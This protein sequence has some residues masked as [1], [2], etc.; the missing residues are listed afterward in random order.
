M[1]GKPYPQKP[2]TPTATPASPANPALAQPQSA[3]AP[4]PNPA[5]V[6]PPPAS[7][8]PGRTSPGSPSAGG[9]EPV[10]TVPLNRNSPAQSTVTSM[11]D[12]S[13]GG[14]DRQK[15]LRSRSA[16][17]KPA[18]L[19]SLDAFRGF[20]MTMLAAG[21]FGLLAFS[22][23]DESSP[24]WQTHNRELWLRIGQHFNHPDW[25]SSFDIFKVSFWDLIQP[26]F[27]FMVGAAMPFS[28][29]RREAEGDGMFSRG[30]HAIT[31]SVMLV[32]LGVF[33][34]S[35][36]HERT[37]WVFPNVLCQI[38][39]G[40]FFAWLLLHMRWTFQIVALM[41]ILF[42][43]WGWFAMTPPPADYDYAAVK[44]SE[45]KGEIFKGKFAAWSRNANA[46]YFVDA[47]LLPRL[48]S[49]P[50]PEPEP[51]SAPESEPKPQAAADGVYEAR[52]ISLMQQNSADAKAEP[53]ALS[54]SET[55]EETNADP[56]EK[57][58]IDEPS[59]EKS[60]DAAP[61]SNAA[62]ALALETAAVT[63]TTLE[64][65]IKPDP[66]ADVEPEAPVEEPAVEQPAKPSW[67]RQWFFSSTEA[68]EPNSGGYTT[69]NFVPSIGTMLLGILCGK[70]LMDKDKSQWAKLGLLIVAATVCLG[71][72]IAADFTACPVVKKIWTPS[73]VLFSGGYVI[74]MLALFYLVFDIAP[75]RLVAF[76]LVVVGTNSI[77]IYLLSQTLSGW[78]QKSVVRV[79]LAGI[80]ENVFGPKA[81]DPLWYGTITLPA[82]VFALYWLFLLWLY[83]QRIFLKL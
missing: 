72:G 34:S 8:S 74:G 36:G 52:F 57:P 3:G 82:T 7:P 38:G 62:E 37:H 6:G 40:Y 5:P 9:A 16:S 65:A 28:N 48:R 43:Y 32:L 66:P 70:L 73:W 10:A 71:L 51:E 78:M 33:L 25:I 54:K 46:A 26:A 30:F 12:V 76:P 41:M 42:G 68:Y 75:L 27:M 56:G 15:R 24:V 4:K 50:A 63:D 59:A 29:A 77:L 69:L 13:R 64:P 47:W 22:R 21:G 14:Q 81:L 80:I 58:A 67:I 39:L 31:R 61:E 11:A 83:R 49:I 79:H 1:A 23:V 44:A 2:L 18:R 53:E 19:V 55:S 45:E 35:V 60:G 17:D 20:I